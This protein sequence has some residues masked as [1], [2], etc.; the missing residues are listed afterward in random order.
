M[1]GKNEN[2]SSGKPGSPVIFPVSALVIVLLLASPLAIPQVRNKVK[3]KVESKFRD[4]LYGD[5]DLFDSEKDK[6]GKLSETENDGVTGQESITDAD[7]EEAREREK[8]EREKIVTEQREYS[9]KRENFNDFISQFR[10][11]K[12]QSEEIS[13]ENEVSVKKL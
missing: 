7:I 8:R 9:T 3:D 1:Q 5:I 11:S 12:T 10:K 6:E 2:D 4:I 13:A